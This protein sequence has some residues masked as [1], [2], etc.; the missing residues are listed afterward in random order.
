MNIVTCLICDSLLHCFHVLACIEY[1]FMH[2]INRPPNDRR[3]E[4]KL[5]K[6]MCHNQQSDN[7]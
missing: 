3:G 5:I 2:H 1:N 4:Q 6:I 7:D